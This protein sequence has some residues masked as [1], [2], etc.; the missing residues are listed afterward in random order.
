MGYPTQYRGNL[1]YARPSKQARVARGYERALT[2][3]RPPSQLLSPATA[4]LFA[5]P[6]LATFGSRKAIGRLAVRLLLTKALGPWGLLFDLI[7]LYQAIRPGTDAGFSMEGGWVVS[8]ECGRPCTFGPYPGNAAGCSGDKFVTEST[9]G[10]MAH[11]HPVSFK[12]WFMGPNKA[13]GQPSTVTSGVR[14]AEYA[15]GW[16]RPCDDPHTTPP[17]PVPVPAAPLQNPVILP[18]SDPWTEPLIGPLPRA[19]KEALAEWPQS[20][21]S[22]EPAGY[23]RWHPAARPNVNPYASPNYSYE[24]QVEIP[25]DKPRLK[26]R[27]R[28]KVDPKVRPRPRERPR[29]RPLERPLDRPIEKYDPW[30]EPKGKPLDRPRLDYRTHTRLDPR[31]KLYVS[32]KPKAPVKEV[33]MRARAGYGAIMALVGTATESLDFFEAMYKALP[34][35]YKIKGRSRFMSRMRVLFKHYDKIAVGRALEEIFWNQAED[36]L[37]GGVGRMQATSVRRL[38]EQGLWGGPFGTTVGG[39]NRQEVTR[40]DGVKV[41]SPTDQ[42]RSLMEPYYR[43]YIPRE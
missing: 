16:E 17:V 31:P 41:A 14:V 21:E 39:A 24:W 23:A 42:L 30:T 5:F 33:K 26:P 13:N 12:V 7:Q 4:K 28:R 32:K 40:L 11:S 27:P 29:E 1:S 2:A 38:S 37:F 22:A 18:W 19:V 35:K 20:Y 43:K 25:S 9:S 10:T 8:V 15:Q 34:E 36:M 6:K 3:Q